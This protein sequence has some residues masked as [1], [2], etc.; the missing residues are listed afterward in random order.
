MDQE[1]QKCDAN[2]LVSSP[3]LVGII[4]LN[5]EESSEFQELGRWYSRLGSCDR[6]VSKSILGSV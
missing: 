6:S 2:D 5:K 3:N 1:D 4:A